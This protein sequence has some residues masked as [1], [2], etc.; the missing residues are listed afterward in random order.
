M[1]L[2]WALLPDEF[3]PLAIAG[4]GLAVILG[5]LRLRKAAALIGGIC[6]LLISGPFFDA[7]FDSL[8]TWIFLLMLPIAAILVIRWLVRL[9]I[10]ERAAD[11]LVGSLAADLC[12]GLILL[13]FRLLG[14]LFKR[15]N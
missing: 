5:F 4:I 15:N 14:F 3:M 10:G 12:R 6:L 1:S 2:L 9:V 11:H 8:P 7:I 13:P